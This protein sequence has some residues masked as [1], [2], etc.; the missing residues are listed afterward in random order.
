MTNLE[1]PTQLLKNPL[2]CKIA[3]QLLKDPFPRPVKVR[4]DSFSPSDKKVRPP[5]I[6]KSTVEKKISL[7]PSEIDGRRKDL[8]G[9]NHE[10][11]DYSM[12]TF[13]KEHL[14]RRISMSHKLLTKKT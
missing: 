4:T 3:T 5:K 7:S 14:C 13:E 12:E 9:N 10:V 6:P 1:I 8:R 2:P 11:Y